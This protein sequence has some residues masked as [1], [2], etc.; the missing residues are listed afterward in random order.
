MTARYGPRPVVAG[1]DGSTS[2]TQAVR[3]A[4]R[5]AAL[6]GCSL[7]LVHAHTGPW[8]HKPEVAG[9][10]GA[11][12]Q[13]LLNLG[14]DWLRDATDVAAGVAP[15]VAVGTEL[16]AS[17]PARLLIRESERARV[18]VVGARGIGG[19]TGLMLGS[20]AA[21]L[22]AH[23]HCPVAVVRDPGAA[24]EPPRSGP[25]VLGVDGSAA[26]ETAIAFAYEA[27]SLRGVPLIA[28]HAW[29][30]VS[31]PASF[32]PMPPTFNWPLIDEDERRLLAQRLAGWQEKYPDVQVHRVVTEGR[33][34]YS[35]LQ[36]AQ[37]AQ[38]IVVGSRG[39]GGLRGLLLGSTSQA[40]LQ[41]APCTVVIARPETPTV[42]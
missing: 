28:V 27:A 39:R 4:A 42:A 41:H 31:I 21:A 9:Q 36:A 10:P 14:Y 35:L 33:P 30:D 37:D 16:T 17:T 15:D 5:Q 1:V 18:V 13:A 24:G 12:R 32:V 25:V 8:I 11:Y 22:G 38:L 2:S 20:A 23:A 6:W 19:F 3:W 34:A 7:R 26:S 40:L 29:S